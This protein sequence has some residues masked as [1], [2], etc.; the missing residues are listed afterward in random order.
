MIRIK[1]SSLKP[2]RRVGRN[3][4]L[5]KEDVSNIQEIA[6]LYQAHHRLK[7][8]TDAEGFLF[9]GFQG[10]Q[11]IGA[12]IAFLPNGK[13]LQK[14]FSLFSP[15]LKLHDQSSHDHWDVLYQNQG[16]TWSY[17]YTEEKWQRHRARKYLKVEKFDNLYAKLIR[18][19]MGA[20]RDKDDLMA[21]P[22]YTLLRTYMRVGNEI[23]F[24]AHGHKGLTT[25]CKGD[26]RIDGNQV[27]FNY[28]GKDGVPI[29]I[30]QTFPKAYITRMRNLLRG[31]DGY[32]FSPKP[33][34]ETD[35][36]RA[37]TKYCG[38]SFYPHI[39][40]SHHAT[41]VVQ[42]YLEHHRTFSQ[43]EIN[44]VFLSIAHDLG[45]K[46]FDKKKECWQDH[47]SVTVNSYIHPKLIA[48]INRILK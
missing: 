44:K 36:K 38:E 42:R 7:L 5:I 13:K 21:L 6:R 20:L 33:L 22:M 18:N 26:V 29:E 47:Y 23:Y 28:V 41:S 31:N 25:L 11:P 34:R 24:K 46:K 3:W 40:R 4:K 9:G 30:S 15:H 16:G 48:K 27:G 37:F 19:V 39:V 14:A 17:V 12:R 45:H 8:I 35:F 43:E 2:Y 1:A 10:G 32:L